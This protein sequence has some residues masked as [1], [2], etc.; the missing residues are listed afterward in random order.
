MRD[1][2]HCSVKGG[3]PFSS[4]VRGR[5][6]RIHRFLYQLIKWSSTAG[7]DNMLDTGYYGTFQTY[8]IT[9]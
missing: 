6:S 8:Q 7:V 2:A 3:S 4:L 9:S 1:L 5:S